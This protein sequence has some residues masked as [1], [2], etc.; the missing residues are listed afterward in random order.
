MS[1]D[2]LGPHMSAMDRGYFSQLDSM[3]T[4]YHPIALHDDHDGA[5][6]S[7]GPREIGQ[8]ANPFMNQLQSL[9]ARIRAGASSVEITFGGVGK[10]NN[11]QGTPEMYGAAERE[12]MRQLAEYNDVKTSTHASFGM[13]G[14]AGFGQRGFDRRAQHANM[15]EVRK[16]VD[17]AAQ[18]TTGG[19]IVVHTGEWERPMSEQHW[20][21]NDFSRDFSGKPAFKGY[22]DEPNKAQMLVVDERTGEFVSGITKDQEIFEPKWVRAG[23]YEKI[24]GKKLTGRYADKNHTKVEHWHDDDFVDVDGNI[25]NPKDTE[26]LFRRLPGWDKENTKFQV[27]KLGWNDIVEKTRKHNERYGTKYTPEEMFAHVQID[28]QALQSRGSSLF[29][30]QQYDQLNEERDKIKRALE[31]ANSKYKHLSKEEQ[32]QALRQE[33]VGRH[34]MGFTDL[35]APDMKDVRVQLQESLDSL[36]K[37]MRHI[38]ESSA[39]AD[40]Q[41][42]Q[43]LERKK[44]LKTL[45]EYGIGETGRALGELGIYAMEKSKQMKERARKAGTIDKYEDIYIAPE[46][47]FPAQ[48]GSHPDELIKIVQ[49]GRDKMATELLDK[50]IAHSKEEAAEIAKKHIKSTIDTG[51]LNMWKTHMVHKPG[52]TDD[53]FNK[54]FEKWALEKIETMHKQGILGHFHLTDNWGFNDEH[55]TPGQGNTPVR[56]I[57]KKLEKLGY[58]DFIVEQSGTNDGTILGESWSYLGVQG[59]KANPAGGRWGPSF[60]QNHWRHAGLYAPANYVHSGYV[61]S[62]EWTLWSGTPLE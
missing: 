41:A 5:K 26:Q 38:H 28:N 20:S 56:S 47:V 12:A 53:Q 27:E 2:Y 57:V 51:H 13:T 58:K 17:F 45:E 39:A 42:E 23:E 6:T 10:G 31:L 54:R 35:I 37:Q 44:R 3:G 33:G 25:V 18:A 52:E 43:L 48:Y 9:Q 14:L 21:K 61:P 40:V 55:L 62:N 8:S 30:G 46:N 16:A 11:Q 29:H 59:F 7:L 36:E 60:S 1:Q 22:A 19:A 49:A 15:E 4:V 50:N 24:T 34:L 32:W